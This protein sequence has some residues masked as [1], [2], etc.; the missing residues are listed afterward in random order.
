MVSSTIRAVS[1]CLVAA[2]ACLPLAAESRDVFAFVQ[3]HC[4]A[5]HNCTVKSGDVDLTLLKTAKTFEDDR[6]IWEKVVEKL[7]LGQMPPPGVAR[8]PQEA[9]AATTR[10]LEGEFARQDLL[11]KP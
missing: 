7:K 10:W 1:V 4:S 5:W 11:V 8:P 9:A 3:S 6:E 2:A